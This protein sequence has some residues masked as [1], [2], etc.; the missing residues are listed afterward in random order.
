MSDTLG[1][2][3]YREEHVWRPDGVVGA[4]EFLFR[5]RAVA[6]FSF[7]LPDH[8]AVRKPS[9]DTSGAMFRLGLVP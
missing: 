7:K 9:Q 5:S 8:R 1:K 4:I 3:C 6:I 2:N